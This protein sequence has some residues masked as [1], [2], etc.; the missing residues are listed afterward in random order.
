MNA[1]L[2]SESSKWE[3]NI[4]D[5][6]RRRTVFWEI[7]TVDV[8][9]VSVLPVTYPDPDATSQLEKS[10]TLG[11]PPAINL[12]FVNCPFPD[13]QVDCPEPDRDKGTLNENHF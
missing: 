5:V 8:I 9:T 6:N 2:D 11:R 3:M 10:S 12:S 7:F 13:E 4:K 1:D